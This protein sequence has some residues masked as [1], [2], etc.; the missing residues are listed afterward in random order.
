MIF[1]L[2]GSRINLVVP[3]QFLENFIFFNFS[4]PYKIKLPDNQKPEQE[5]YKNQPANNHHDISGCVDESLYYM[6]N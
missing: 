4:L 6:V 2:L 1:H 3:D 5:A